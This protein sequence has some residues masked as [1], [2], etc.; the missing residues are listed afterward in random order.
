MVVIRPELSKAK[1]RYFSFLGP[2]GCEYVKSYLEKRMANGEVIQPVSALISVK[3]GYEET[4]FRQSDR[5]DQHIT[6]K[7]LTKEIRDA[8]RPRFD[9]RPYVLRSYFDT[10]LMVA[11]NNGKIAHAYRQFFM[12]HK[13]DI[14]ARYTT[15]KGRLPDSVIEDMRTAYEKSLVYL[16]TRK[17]D[18]SEDRLKEAMRRQLLLVA[19]FSGNEIDELDRDMND[20]DFQKIIRKK[21]MGTMYNNGNPQKVIKQ[22]EITQYLENGWSFVATLKDDQAIVKLP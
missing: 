3:Q 6:T 8:M 17:A 12:G 4:G 1:H 19:G 13:G 14:E 11:E 5:D 16:E 7:T 20:E 10:Q 2:E 15:H 22:D 18:I 21:L 9:W